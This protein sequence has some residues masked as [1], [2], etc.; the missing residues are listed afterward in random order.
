MPVCLDAGAKPYLA[1]LGTCCYH[2]LSSDGLRAISFDVSEILEA[3][4]TLTC[5]LDPSPKGSRYMVAYTWALAGFLYPY[6]ESM[7]VLYRYLDPVGGSFKFPSCFCVFWGF[8]FE[9]LR[10]RLQS[11]KPQDFYLR[12]APRMHFSV[13]DFVIIITCG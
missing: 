6:L 5:A 1:L 13:E 12:G 3:G 10:R 11:Q 9:L 8:L 2:P 7:Y 4:A